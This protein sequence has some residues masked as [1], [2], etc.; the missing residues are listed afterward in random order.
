MLRLYSERWKRVDKL[1]KDKSRTAVNILIIVVNHRRANENVVQWWYRLK[2]WHLHQIKVIKHTESKSSSLPLTNMVN[3]KCIKV[4]AA[5]NIVISS[6]F[7]YL[8]K[9]VNVGVNFSYIFF[10]LRKS[11]E[12]VNS[13]RIPKYNILANFIILN[14]ISNKVNI[15]INKIIS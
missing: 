4:I 3:P 12:Y 5:V 9:Y 2:L 7:I 6:K 10:N 14:E 1:V 8:T 11:I 15:I 13:V